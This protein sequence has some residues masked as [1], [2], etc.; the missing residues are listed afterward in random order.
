MTLRHI[1][2]FL[3][4]CN[5]DCNTTK[6]ACA[7]HMTQ[8]AVSLAIKELEEYY[9][10]RFFERMGKKLKI[11]SVGLRF[12]E[13]ALRICGLFDDMERE[14]RNWDSFGVLRVGASVTI[15]SQFLP[16][17]VKE[18]YRRY[19]NT[20]IKVSIGSS[21]RIE[22]AIRENEL[23]F[24]LIEGIPHAPD[25]TAEEY[26]DDHLTVICPAQGSFPCGAEISIDEFRRQP[27]LLRENGSGTREVFD[28]AAQAAGFS[29]SP[30][31]EATSTAALV[32]AV[33]SGLGIAVVPYRMVQ[34]PIRRGLVHAVTVRGMDFS[35]KF[36]IIYHKDKFLTD[37]A[38]HF[39][40]LC[41]AAAKN[42]AS[43]PLL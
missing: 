10:V 26:M 33:I 42:T 6:A 38:K 1:K 39:L 25:F 37:S 35:R 40:E 34:Q 41:R 36:H 31:W 3:S 12:Q 30:I 2:L 20:Q 19:P 27:F 11:T 21:D 9:G 5:H 32:N 13:Y 8:P 16:G 43:S 15:G 18:F 24:G 28:Q 14:L 7:L 23:D 4:V 29:V 22:N 17:Y